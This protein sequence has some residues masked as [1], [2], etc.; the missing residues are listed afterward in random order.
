MQ[1][2]IGGVVLLSLG[3]PAI[4]IG[5]GSLPLIFIYPLMKRVTYWPQAFLGLAF[6]W[7][8]LVGFAAQAGDLSAPAFALYAAGVSWTLGYDTIY[9]HQDKEDDV[10]IG[11]KSTALLFGAQTKPWLA[12]FYI[13]TT[14][15]LA[16]AG[17]LAGLAWPFFLLLVIA[18]AQLAWQIFAVSLDAAG[19]CLAKFKSNRLFGWMVLSAVVAGGL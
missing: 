17:T 4:W 6:N 1:M 14:G 19:D 11:V 5:L 8:A 2:M 13:I 15:L 3:V 10:L 18:A 7:G 12:G 16:L 9:A